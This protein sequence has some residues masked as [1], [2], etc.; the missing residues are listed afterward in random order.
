MH[1]FPSWLNK[2]VYMKIYYL[3]FNAFWLAVLVTFLA[4]CCAT[5]Y[6]IILCNE[7]CH[8]NST[9]WFLYL[10]IIRVILSKKKWFTIFPALSFCFF[11]ASQSIY[12]CTLVTDDGWVGQFVAPSWSNQIWNLSTNSDYHLIGMNWPYCRQVH[13]GNYV[14]YYIYS[15]SSCWF[16]R[17]WFHVFNF[18]FEK[19]S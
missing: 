10:Y 17:K 14:L 2:L 19:Q 6:T 11:L 15:I 5:P 12:H 3:S 16:N 8:L 7:W 1:A 13:Y 18:Q 9:K 4:F